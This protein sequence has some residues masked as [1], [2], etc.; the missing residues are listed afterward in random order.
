[1]SELEGLKLLRRIEEGVAGKTGEAFFRQIIVDLARALQAHSAFCSRLVADRRAA[2]LAFWV[3]GEFQP[4]VEYVLDGT[5]CEFVY[6]GRIMAFARD[7][8]NIFP[9]DREWFATL[10]VNSY[11]GIPVKSESAEVLGH[12][13]VMDTRERDWREADVDILRLFSLRFAAELERARYEAELADAKRQADE[14]N[15]AKS[16]FLTQMSHELRTPLNGLLGYAQL[17]ERE[18]GLRPAHLANVAAMRH[19]GE[20]LLTLINEILDLARI[21]SGTTMLDPAT[22]DP[23]E[24]LDGVSDMMRVRAREA[25]IAFRSIIDGSLPQAVHADARRLRQVLLNLLGNAI[26][27]T[28]QGEVELAVAVSTWAGET[29]TLRIEVRDTGPGIPPE[30]LTRIFEPF[31]QVRVPGRQVEGSGLGLSISRAI[32]EAMGGALVVESELGAGTTFRLTIELPA[33]STV[34]VEP[35]RDTP[36]VVGYLGR[37]RS[38]LVAD[39]EPHNRDVLR[40]LFEPLGFT[41]LEA[42]NGVEALQAMEQTPPD[43]L[44]IDLVMPVMDGLTVMRTL[45][46]QPEFEATPVIALSASAFAGTISE[47]RE[48]GCTEFLP[49]PVSFDL[50]LD[51]VGRTLGLEWIEQPRAQQT[52]PQPADAPTGDHPDLDIPPATARRLFDLALRGDVEALASE[53]DSLESERGDFR[54]LAARLRSLASAYDMKGVRALIG[55]VVAE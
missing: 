24:L 5:P 36:R 27:F 13:A 12:L 4:C 43:L 29:A 34:T 2:M 17:L 26:K 8:G 39:D 47:C 3:D 16:L 49:K 52:R 48:A 44:L 42:S 20:H 6:Q 35:T 11:L 31:H 45:R 18:P 53:I 37:R 32:V 10:G 7:I 46:A 33:P 38:L 30:Q 15:Q 51:A 40:Q 28:V 1:M 19:C 50:L 41:V 55:P 14:A 23:R 22:F 25:G 54:E 21:E 9:V